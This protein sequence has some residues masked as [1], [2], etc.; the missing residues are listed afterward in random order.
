MG[1]GERTFTITLTEAQYD[2]FVAAMHEADQTWAT[3]GILRSGNRQTLL[4][5]MDRLG[6]A[7]LSG[8]KA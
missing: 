5:A 4:R 6:K 1:D 2:T 8:K 3:L 7:W